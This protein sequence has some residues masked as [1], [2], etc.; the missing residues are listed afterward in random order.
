MVT[1]YDIAK[2]CGVSPSTVSKVVNNYQSIPPSTRDKILKAME[3]LN[4]I[5]NS[6]ATY[7][8]KGKSSIIGIL[9][10]FGTKITPFK[11][12]LFNEILDSFQKEMNKNKYDLMFISRTVGKNDGT[13]LQ[14][15]ISRNVDGVLMLGNM[16]HKEM[17]E[18]SNSN[19]PSVGFDYF[20]RNMSGVFSNNYRLMY[21]LTEHLLKFNHKDIVFVCG[22]ENKITDLRVGAFVDCLQK[23]GIRISE[24][25]IIKTKYVDFNKLEQIIED[26]LSRKNRPTAIMFPDDYSAIRGISLLNKYGLECPRDIS[27]TG[28]DGIRTFEYFVPRLTTARQNTEKIGLSLANLLISSIENKDFHELIEVPGEI[29][30]G[31]STRKI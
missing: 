14:N 21:Q 30:I 17:K 2:H 19:I 13:F 18:V 3:E 5:P 15:C 12:S 23:Y 25:N 1:I 16:D 20:G 26:I 11:H 24:K 29:L 31:D 9:S 22:D 8:S 4:Y 27:I 6:S 10:C 28:F 7:L